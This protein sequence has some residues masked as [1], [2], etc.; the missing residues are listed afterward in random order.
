M[1]GFFEVFAGGAIVLTG[2]AVGRAGFTPGTIEVLFETS[3]AD[4]LATYAFSAGGAEGAAD[5]FVA[6]SSAGD[7]SLHDARI[8]L[9]EVAPIPLPAALPLLLAGAGALVLVRR[10]RA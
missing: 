10:R 6:L 7:L 4:V 3:G 2:D 9:S 1:S 5:P 8:T